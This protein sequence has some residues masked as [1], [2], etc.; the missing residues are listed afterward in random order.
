MGLFPVNYLSLTFLYGHRKKP[1][2]RRRTPRPNA[3]REEA[4]NFRTVHRA[5]IVSAARLLISSV[6]P[7]VCKFCSVSWGNGALHRKHSYKQQSLE[8]PVDNLERC[9]SHLT[10]FQSPIECRSLYSTLLLTLCLTRIFKKVVSRKRK[11]GSIS[12]QVTHYTDI[13][14]FWDIKLLLILAI[15]LGEYIW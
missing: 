14:Y 12:D 10:D 6:L 4:D 1:A 9:A 11:K 8:V 2:S 15:D 3:R 7:Y 5:R 13:A